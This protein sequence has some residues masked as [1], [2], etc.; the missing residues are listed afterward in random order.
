MNGVTRLLPVLL[1]LLT[2]GLTTAACAS[3]INPSSDAIVSYY[4]YYFLN[5]DAGT[6]QDAPTYSVTSAANAS[7]GTRDSMYN[8]EEAGAISKTVY[9]NEAVLIFP[10]AGLRASAIQPGHIQLRFYTSDFLSWPGYP[11]YYDPNRCWYHK[12]A[13]LGP[14]V[15]AAHHHRNGSS[16]LIGWQE[17]T[18]L[19]WRTIDVT[20]QVL[21]DLAAGFSY[22]TFMFDGNSYEGGANGPSFADVSQGGHIGASEGP[23]GAYLDVVVVPEPCSASA[24]ACGLCGIVGLS[25]RN[26]T[27]RRV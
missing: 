4:H 19:G 11:D 25:L 12:E 27:R 20:Q 22:S 14:T 7:L 2:M 5:R 23:N 16:T 6:C 17:Y 15:T 10:I 1:L 13:D 24:I 8:W 3:R 21:Q 9:D 18:T 26:R